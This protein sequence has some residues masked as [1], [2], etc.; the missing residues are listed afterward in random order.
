MLPKGI[1]RYSI[2]QICIFV[3]HSCQKLQNKCCPKCPPKYL[4][5]VQWPKFAFFCVRKI[6][7]NIFFNCCPKCPQKSFGG[8]QWQKFA[9]L[10][11]QNCKK[12]SKKMKNYFVPNAPKSQWPI[13]IFGQPKM[14]KTVKNCQKQLSWGFPMNKK[15][16]FFFSH[17]KCSKIKKLD[18]IFFKY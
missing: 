6:P 10:A 2:T 3:G 18:K 15:F 13:C 16:V 11:A 7:T 9:I 17:P 5:G 4:G 8:V 14:P 1:W 12:L